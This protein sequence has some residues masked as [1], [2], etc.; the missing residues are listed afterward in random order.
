MYVA[1]RRRCA[2]GSRAREATKGRARE[3]YGGAASSSRGH[4]HLKRSTGSAR[5]FT[6]GVHWTPLK[7]RNALFLRK[8]FVH[9]TQ[10]TVSSSTMYSWLVEVVHVVVLLVVLGLPLTFL[11]VGFL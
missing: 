2:G 7:T 5:S 3:A 9:Y 1:V 8:E 6:R 4:A 11:A 10:T